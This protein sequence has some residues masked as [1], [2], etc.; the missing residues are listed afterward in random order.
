MVAGPRNRFSFRNGSDLGDAMQGIQG[1]AKGSPALSIGSATGFG[2]GS[3]QDMV[4]RNI[5]DEFRESIDDFQLEKDEMDKLDSDVEEDE[6]HGSVCPS[7]PAASGTEVYSDAPEDEEV[8][9]SDVEIPNQDVL[10]KLSDLASQFTRTVEK[11]RSKSLAPSKASTKS[12][13]SHR[14]DRSCRMTPPLGGEELIPNTQPSDDEEFE[15]DS[16]CSSHTS[17]KKLI[18]PWRSIFVKMRDSC[19]EEE[20]FAEFAEYAMHDLAKAGPSLDVKIKEDDLGGYKKAHVSS[21]S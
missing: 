10:E 7:S 15:K 6:A 2:A 21:F 9:D 3:D 18:A 19:T 13:V 11:L 12:S 17:R 5:D 20:A 16:V 4:A 14:S 1:G 8:N